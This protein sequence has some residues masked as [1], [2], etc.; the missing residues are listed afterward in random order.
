M[1]LTN[2]KEFILKNFPR[3]ND[4]A[5]GY[6]KSSSKIANYLSGSMMCLM[7]GQTIFTFCF[8]IEIDSSLVSWIIIS[9]LVSIAISYV[10]YNF[11]KSFSKKIKSALDEQNSERFSSAFYYLKGMLLLQFLS[12]LVMV[13]IVYFLV[14]NVLM[15]L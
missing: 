3:L 8:L 15:G 4:L 6:L 13:V 5:V 9:Y 10:F 14:V 11:Y 7:I 1:A 12:S 2:T